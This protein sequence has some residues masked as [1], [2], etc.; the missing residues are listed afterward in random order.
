MIIALV[1]LINFIKA[2]DLYRPPFLF[3]Y[4]SW[5][6]FAIYGILIIS[7]SNPGNDAFHYIHRYTPGSLIKITIV[8]ELKNND[9][10]F[11]YTGEIVGINGFKTRGKVLVRI[12]KNEKTDGIHLDEGNFYNSEP[13]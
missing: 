5:I 6:L 3:I 8:E 4:S 11:K 12:S 7:R 1:F 9:F 13:F 10:Y 2:Q